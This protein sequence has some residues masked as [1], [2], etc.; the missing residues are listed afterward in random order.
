[1][2]ASKSR[3]TS[4][5]VLRACALIKFDLVS[6][7]VG[8]Y[9]VEATTEI[10]RGHLCDCSGVLSLVVGDW[11]GAS[12]AKFRAPT[13]EGGPSDMK[14]D[15]FPANLQQVKGVAKGGVKRRVWG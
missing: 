11:E 1:M 4:H 7:R 12:H 13:E 9:L 2:C 15:V 10:L 6:V 8:R 14:R 5:L 3:S